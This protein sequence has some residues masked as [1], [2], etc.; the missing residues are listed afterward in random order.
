MFLGS[1]ST[2]SGN[3]VPDLIS[4]FPETVEKVLRRVFFSKA[5]KRPLFVAENSA[6]NFVVMTESCSGFHHLSRAGCFAF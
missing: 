5:S 2:F 3:V 6:E 1:F 4:G